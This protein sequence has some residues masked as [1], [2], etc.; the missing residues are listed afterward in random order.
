MDRLM[1]D[2]E[3]ET[4]SLKHVRVT[5]QCLIRLLEQQI[6]VQQSYPITSKLAEVM[7]AAARALKGGSE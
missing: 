2:Q 5:C 1:E 3:R 4:W 7:A 6:G